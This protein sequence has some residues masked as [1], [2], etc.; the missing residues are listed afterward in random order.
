[1]A[2][3]GATLVVAGFEHRVSLTGLVKRSCPEFC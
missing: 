3:V 1:L 2:A